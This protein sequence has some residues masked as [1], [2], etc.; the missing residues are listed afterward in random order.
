MHYTEASVDSMAPDTASAPV[1]GV[2]IV[3]DQRETR[4]GL[5]LLINGAQNFECRHVYASM[6]A[7][8]EG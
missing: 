4:E 8:L 3:E 1:I 5:S 6:E 2:A 7:A